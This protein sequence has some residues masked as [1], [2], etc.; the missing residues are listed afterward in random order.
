VTDRSVGRT[1]IEGATVAVVCAGYPGKRR[2]L[3]RMAELGARLV[4]LDEPGHWASSLVDD[5]LAAH[6]LPVAV[7]GDPEADASAVLDALGRAGIRPE[8]VLTFWE[9]SVTVVARVAAALGLPGHA[10]PGVDAARSKIRTRELSRELGLPSPASRRVRTLADLLE[11]GAEIGFPAIVKPEFGAT[12]V[13]CVRVD[14]LDELPDVYEAVRRVVD[15]GADDIFRAGVDLVLEEYL[16]G[17]EFDVDMVMQHGRCEFASVSQAW[18]TLEPAFFETGLHCP[19]D[20]DAGEV[21]QLVDLS[22]D[23]AVA[24]GLGDGVLHIEGKCTSRGPRIVEVN[25]RMGG[26]RI[27]EMVRS[28]WGVDL[29]EEHLRASLGI[30]VAVPRS[31][32]PLAGVV[33]ILMYAPASGRLASLPIDPGAV[34]ECM[35]FDVARAIG[36]P[37]TG[38]EE[39]F[40]SLIGE[41][42]ITGEDL[43]HARQLAQPILDSPPTVVP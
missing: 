35:A 9:D 33:D 24:F 41:I 23:T 15:P 34:P 37:V 31:A 6:W 12:S 42:W 32:E 5:G 7:T 13:G 27:R 20:H 38:P 2:A 40:A 30:P 8:G 39:V 1:G 26:R 16:D 14:R 11:A 3:V 21:Q 19:P 17:V 28:V 36:E 43:E 4:V 18:P 29:V 10:V 25:A 22:I